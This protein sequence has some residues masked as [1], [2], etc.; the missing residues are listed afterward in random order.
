[1]NV[2]VARTNDALKIN[3]PVGDFHL[4]TNGSDWLWA[5]T[6]IYALSLLVVIGLTYFAKAGEKIF[7][8]LFTISL[9]VGTIS[10]FA[11]ASDLGSTPV[12]TSTQ[13]DGLRQIFYVRYIN[14]FVG[15]TPLVLAIGL[16]SGVSWATIIFNIALT[17]IWVSS[18]LSGALVATTYK[19]GFFVFGTFAYFLLAAS[20]LTSG[21]TTAKRLNITKSYLILAG[22][23]VF[24]WFLYPIAWGVDDG[25]NVISVT[26]G[27]IYI[28]I[29][30]LFT[31]PFFAFAVLFLITKL[32]YRSLNLYFTQYGRVAPAEYPEGPA[33]EK[34]DPTATPAVAEPA[35]PAPAV[36]TPENT[37]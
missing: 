31:V 21:L 8:Y 24:F 20:L 23:L 15:W 10:Y 34:V 29:L 9:F 5:V 19:W 32:E 16:I 26:S 35:A 27:F 13:D 18:W 33:V 14:W 17:W 12:E 4:V 1:M 28:G 2:L 6:A 7:H 36:T 37:V 25:G 22:Y 30:D 11:M 3:P